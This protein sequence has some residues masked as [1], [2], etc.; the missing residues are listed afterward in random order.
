MV[1]VRATV[2]A[3]S[4]GKVLDELQMPN[5]LPGCAQPLLRAGVRR[6]QA[7]ASD[8]DT[9]AESDWQPPEK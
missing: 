7:L 2:M 3:K 4:R 5:P 9:E 6:L 1:T 8:L